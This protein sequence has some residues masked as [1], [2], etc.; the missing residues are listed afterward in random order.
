MYKEY[1]LRCEVWN[2]LDDW[3]KCEMY[4]DTEEGIERVC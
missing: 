3:G 1:L 4:F 2:P